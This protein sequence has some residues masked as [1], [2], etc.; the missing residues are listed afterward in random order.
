MSS[1]YKRTQSYFQ[2]LINFRIKLW[3]LKLWSLDSHIHSGQVLF[4][5]NLGLQCMII[6]EL[7]LS[8]EFLDV[9]EKGFSCV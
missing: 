4:N 5:F 9:P 3:T 1:I 6:L 2:Y 8:V 7:K